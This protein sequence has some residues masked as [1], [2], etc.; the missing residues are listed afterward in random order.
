MRKEELLPT[1]DCEAGYGPGIS[2]STKP[3]SHNLQKRSSLEY[4]NIYQELFPNLISKVLIKS[5][6][7]SK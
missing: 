5:A 4:W 1:Q 7:S 2:S 6:G 3:E